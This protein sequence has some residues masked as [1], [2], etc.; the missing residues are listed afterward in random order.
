MAISEPS[1]RTRP[2][3]LIRLRDQ[4]RDAWRSFVGTYAAVIHGFLRKQGIQEADA[5]DIVQD[6][7]A[8]VAARLGDFDH[9]GDRRGSFRKWLFT[10]TR[11]RATDHWRREHRQPRGAGDSNVQRVLAELPVEDSELEDRWDREYLETVFQTATA[12]VKGDFQPTTW[13][14]FWKSTVEHKPPTAVAAETGLTL[15]AVYLA[16]RR[17]LQR[18]QKHIEFLEG[19]L[20]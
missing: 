4:D 2:S 9:R 11:T 16:R 12:Q 10:I 17:V 20:A 7:L 8:T 6:V 19:G 3:L 14:A 15:R 5:L 18:L 13:E 1:L